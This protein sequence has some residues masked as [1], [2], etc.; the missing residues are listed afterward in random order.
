MMGFARQIAFVLLFLTLGAGGAVAAGF[1][2]GGDVQNPAQMTVAD[3]QALPPTNVSVTFLTSH[4]PESGSYTG[5]L[6]WTLLNNAVIAGDEKSRLHHTVLVSGSDGYTVAI[7]VGELDPN[8]EGKQVIIAYAKDGQ[9][10]SA[11]EGL[12]LIVPGD[13]HGGRAVKD[14]VHIEV[15]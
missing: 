14:V 9:P 8:F 15:K 13:K 6:L 12:R 5:V 3:L 11:A 4:G 10:L 2:L 7:A 1:S